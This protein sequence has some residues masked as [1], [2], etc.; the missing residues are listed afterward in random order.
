MA[1]VSVQPKADI[2]YRVYVIPGSGC[3]GMAPI[4]EAYFSGL[5]FAEVFVVHKQHVDP[6]ARPD[7]GACGDAFVSHDDLAVWARE[8]EWF[9]SWHLAHDPPPQGRSLVVVGSSEGAEVLP[10]FARAIPGISLVAT[11]GSTGLD[12]LEALSLQADRQGAPGFVQDLM[13]KVNDPG[14]PDAERYAGRSMAYW[15]SLAR[16]RLAD[17]LMELPHPL[18]MGFGGADENVPLEGLERFRARTAERRRNVCVRVFPAAD[19]GLQRQGHDDLQ[20][21]WGMLETALLGGSAGTDCAPGS[22]LSVP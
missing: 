21:F 18:W 8:V 7:P 4:A 9:V 5:R 12:P 19:H 14:L 16:W 22:S 15:R 11:V 20:V 10:Q 1:Y 6:W 17:P 2:R 13:A 3:R